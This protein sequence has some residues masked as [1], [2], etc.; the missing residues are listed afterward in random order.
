MSCFNFY[1]LVLFF[2]T[3]KGKEELNKTYNV[4]PQLGSGGFGTVYSGTRKSDGLAVSLFI[5]EK[6]PILIFF[7]L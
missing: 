1:L 5:R 6:K 7:V 4:G 3:V 2:F